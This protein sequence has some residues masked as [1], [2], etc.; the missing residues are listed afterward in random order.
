MTMPRIEPPWLVEARKYVGLSEIPGPQ[1]N[2]V[3]VGW[4]R[5]LKAWWSEDE[6][7][8][9]G[10]YTAYCIDAA[11]FKLPQHW[12]RAKAWADW[13]IRT[14]EPDVGSIVVFERK[15]GGHVGFV[16][17]RDAKGR[18]MVLGGNQGNK[19]S[20]APFD[21]DRVLCYVWPN[22]PRIIGALP[23][24]ASAAPSSSNEA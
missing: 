3:I 5:R 24:L 22:T 2:Q 7:A 14:D 12:Y 9:C 16:V 4:L 17:G 18:L 20:I 21:T 8:W 13:G 6:T 19:V 23:V 11:G 10:A 15:G 1:H